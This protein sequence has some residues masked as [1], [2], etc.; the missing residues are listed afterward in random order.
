MRMGLS[1]E[2]ILRE[3]NC[4]ARVNGGCAGSVSFGTSS[5]NASTGRRNRLS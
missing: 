4:N 2:G 5:L 1:G 3:P